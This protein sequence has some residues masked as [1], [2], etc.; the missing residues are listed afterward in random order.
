MDFEK[1]GAFLIAKTLARPESMRSQG[2]VFTYKDSPRHSAVVTWMGTSEQR[3]TVRFSQES[4]RHAWRALEAGVDSSKTLSGVWV[5]SAD[6]E[7]LEPGQ[8]YAVQ[9]CIDG[10]VVDE[11]TFR[12]LPAA[13]EEFTFL[14]GADSH[15]WTPGSDS[16]PRRRANAFAAAADPAFV[17]LTGDLWYAN[18]GY[19]KTYGEGVCVHNVRRWFQE[20]HDLM[21]TP[22]G[23]RIPLIPAKGNHDCEFFDDVFRLP[24]PAGA[25]ALRFGPD[26]AIITVS[27]GANPTRTRWLEQ[28]LQA[29]QD[30]RWLIVQ[31]HPAPYPSYLP[32]DEPYYQSTW[33]QDVRQHWAPLFDAYGVDL[34]LSGHCHAFMKSHPIRNN[35]ID[36]SGVV[37]LVAGAW[38]G[39]HQAADGD[40]WYVDMHGGVKGAHFLNMTLTPGAKELKVTAV[41]EQGTNPSFVLRKN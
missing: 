5:Y 31:Q 23:H 18:A 16:A 39:G 9:L 10:Q 33:I 20:W 14:V 34:V 2:I 17:L 4:E 32:F 12:T 28:T 37:Y 38:T 6:L 40:R 24:D 11:S 21:R 3:G 41:S 29:H 8:T 35:Q 30:C 25:Y 7:G 13:G 15:I 27:G 19:E 1:W 22:M 26:L 36:P